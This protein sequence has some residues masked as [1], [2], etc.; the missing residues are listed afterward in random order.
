MTQ[1]CTPRYNTLYQAIGRLM[2]FIV[3]PT[4][5]GVF[6][7]PL[8]VRLGEAW[9]GPVAAVFAALALAALLGNGYLVFLRLERGQGASPFPFCILAHGLSAGAARFPDAGWAPTLAGVVAL[10]VLEVF[11]AWWIGRALGALTRLR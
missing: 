2:G 3:A 9:R 4:A 1:E 11:G 7:I 8:W 6:G 5:L 10:L